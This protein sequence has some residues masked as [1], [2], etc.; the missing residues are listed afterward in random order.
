MSSI[1][2]YSDAVTTADKSSLPSSEGNP[3]ELFA[4]RLQTA[5]R[6]HPGTQMEVHSDSV[7]VLRVTPT[8]PDVT[9]ILSDG[10]CTL[11][12]GPW[13]EDMESLDATVTYVK[14]A[15]CGDLRV[16]IDNLG[17]KPWQYALERHL[18]DGSWQ[19]ES[20]LILPR[21]SLWA[22]QKTTHYLHNVH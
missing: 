2:S 12:I 21:F 18:E 8:G 16:R 15:V 6:D 3:V 19:E 7:T 4:H 22:K 17:G 9:A 13:H 14:M 10:R 5:L 11:A 20:V 1:A